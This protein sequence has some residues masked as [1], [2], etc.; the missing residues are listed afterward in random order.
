MDNPHA[1]GRVEY[2]RKLVAERQEK[3]RKFE[4]DCLDEDNKTAAKR[5]EEDHK[6][7]ADRLKED[8]QVKSRRDYPMSVLNEQLMTST[9]ALDVLGLSDET[10]LT[11]EDIYAGWTWR[12]AGLGAM[13]RVN[14]PDVSRFEEAREVLLDYTVKHLAIDV[15]VPPMDHKQAAALLEIFSSADWDEIERA[16]NHMLY[17]VIPSKNGVERYMRE[18][19]MDE[20]YRVMKAKY[21][22]DR[23]RLVDTKRLK[24]DK[25]LADEGLVDVQAAIAAERQKID[26]EK[27]TR[28]A[29]ERQKAEMIEAEKIAAERLE[30]D[31]RLVPLRN[32]RPA[33]IMAPPAKKPESG[34]R[35][36]RKTSDIDGRSELIADMNRVFAERFEEAQDKNVPVNEVYD[37]FRKSTSLA[38]PEFSVFKQHCRKIFRAKWTHSQV[39]FKGNDYFF[40]GMAVKLD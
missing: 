40:T 25:S 31:R 37:V 3:K 39:V 32:E 8:E 2:D 17:F 24:T 15:T 33:E 29:A 14:V 27:A 5:L 38:N 11:M 23:A 28:V 20:A 4:T 9:I 35:K 13:C 30:E 7:A 34:K 16:Y 18:K 6:T 26:A 1:A 10:P 21:F 36:H 19:K 12:M 22:R